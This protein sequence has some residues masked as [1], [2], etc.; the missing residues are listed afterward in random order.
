MTEQANTKAV[1]TKV[2]EAP[3]AEKKQ[4]EPDLSAA[5]LLA[6][7]PQLEV[8]K[9]SKLTEKFG[10][11]ASAAAVDQAKAALTAKTH[12]V[13]VVKTKTEALELLISLA[14]AKKTYGQGGSTTL[15]ELGWIAWLKDHPEAFGH[16]YKA[17]SAEAFAKGDWGAAGVANK[18][19]LSADVFFTSADA[20][21]QEGDIIACDQTG[22]R[23]GAFAH[24]AGSLIVVV[25]SNKIVPDLATARQRQEE[26]SLPLESARARI[27]YA[28]MGIK[29][30]KIAT[31][32]EIRSGNP[33]GAPGRIHVIIVQD[34]V[35]GF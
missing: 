33:F 19:G 22:T 11:K 4:A 15:V 2:T 32:V 3:A 16:N 8:L 34:E 21:T 35:L 12:K 17:D 25:G 1:E 5:G 26:Y 7:D 9:T 10:V 13:T 27:A 14:D 23:T 30:S 24:T 6:S 28:A 18:L 20:I 29:A 31:V